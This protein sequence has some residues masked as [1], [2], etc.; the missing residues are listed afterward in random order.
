MSKNLK[1]VYEFAI[2]KEVEKVIE[3][4]KME[5]EQE[6]KIT[7]TEKVKEP[8][9]FAILKPGRKLYDSAEIF[10]AKTVSYYI[11]E[12]LMPISLVAKRFGN[13]GGVLTDKESEYMSGLDVKMADC[14]K[15][16]SEL[17]TQEKAVETAA[18]DASK[19]TD[20]LVEML[21][22]QTEI[23][24]IKNSFFILYDNTAEMKAR[25]K[26]IEWWITQLSF[27]QN[28]K[29]E[30][31]SYFDQLSFE[32]RY[33]LYSAILDG[34]DLFLKDT[35]NKFTYLISSWLNSDQS[36]TTEQFKGL[37]ENFEETIKESVR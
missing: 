12:G 31:V 25:K 15:R 35:M 14:Q 7:R 8:V 2:D 30:Y 4:K 34:E 13:D 28:E 33:T 19:Q 27:I 22:I 3:E 5:G 23:E 9:K 20:I 10:L 1:F 26:S 36:L 11:K 17:K 29:G 6:I 37:D 16:L 24:K 21:K 32:E 18:E